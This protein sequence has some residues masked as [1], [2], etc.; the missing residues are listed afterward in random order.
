[1]T[2]DPQSSVEQKPMKSARFRLARF[3]PLE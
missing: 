1:M 2:T 3:L